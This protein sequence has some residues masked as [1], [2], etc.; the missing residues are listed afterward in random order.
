M[1]LGL[2]KGELVLA[3]YSDEWPRRFDEAKAEIEGAIG[4]YVLDIQHVGSTSVPGLM[5]KPILDI[6]VAVADFEEARR[7]VGPMEALGYQYKGENGIPRRHYF[8]LFRLPGDGAT[9]HHV[10]MNEIGSHGWRAQIAFRDALRHNA[11]LRDAYA[12]LKS[13]LSQ[14]TAGSRLAYTDSKTGFITK[15]LLQQI[16]SLLPAVGDEVTVRAFKADNRC[17]RHWQTTIEAASVDEIITYSEAGQP[18]WDVKG[19]WTSKHA[20]RCHYWVDKPYN[21]LEIYGSDGS[22]MELYINIG[23]PARLVDGEIHFTDYELDVV[24]F[25][26]EV[27]KIVDEDEFA[28]AAELFGY[29]EAFQDFCYA[30]THEAVALA[31]SWE[32]VQP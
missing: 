11:E 12:T 9:I 5:A 30:A 28:E 16:P 17:C 6:G 25:P 20:I 23:S 18:V 22:L 19:E 3:P 4:A 7:C 27:A 26:G 2:R 21:V 10:H 13:S 29:T 32:M 8:K 31:N 1:A 15:V 24:R 14:S